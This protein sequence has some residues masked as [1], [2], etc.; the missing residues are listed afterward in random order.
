MLNSAEIES[1]LSKLCVDLGFCLSPENEKL[2]HEDPAS[3]V[4]GFTDA[5][6]VAEG[7]NPEHADRSL[8]RQVREVVREAFEKHKKDSFNDFRSGRD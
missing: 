7:L 2:L 6:F 5:V 8:H 4:N 3:D 1:L